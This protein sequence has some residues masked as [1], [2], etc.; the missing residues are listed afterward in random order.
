[1]NCKFCILST[2][3]TRKTYV[4]VGDGCWW[5]VMLVTI[6][7][8]HRCHRSKRHLSQMIC[9]SGVKI[10]IV[11]I[12]SN[13]QHDESS[14]TKITIFNCE[15][16]IDW[17]KSLLTVAMRSPNCK[18]KNHKPKFQNVMLICRKF[19]RIAEDSHH[20]SQQFRTSQRERT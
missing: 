1:M 7:S 13:Q 10:T 12:N 18:E 14:F 15:R 8:L 9:P 5:R 2:V 16:T 11:I 4:D 6:F 3:L 17:S 20:L 19:R